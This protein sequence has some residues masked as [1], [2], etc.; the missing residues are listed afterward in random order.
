MPM[1]RISRATCRRPTLVRFASQHVAQHPSAGERRLRV[2]P[3]DDRSSTP[4]PLRKPARV[5]S[6]KL[7]RERSS[8]PAWR[9][10]GKAWLAIDHRFALDPSIRPSARSKKSF[11]SASWPILACSS[12]TSGPSCFGL[13]AI[14]SFAGSFEELRLPLDDRVGVDVEAFGD[15]SDGLI[16]LD[17]REG[18]LSLE[19]RSVVAAGTFHDDLLL[20]RGSF[21]PQRV[22][23]S[24]NGV[25]G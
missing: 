21:A 20:S 10:N 17:R 23:S 15:L 25:F 22:K 5:C 3:I 8:N 14:E 16:A 4:D 2:H 13:I 12:L 1:R 6:T 18:H 11:S 19:G 24:H 9:V 7:P